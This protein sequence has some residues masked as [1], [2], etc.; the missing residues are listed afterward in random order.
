MVL[1]VVSENYV[2]GREKREAIDC[3]ESYFLRPIQEA[4]L[5]EFGERL[6]VKK[7]TKLADHVGCSASEL[8]R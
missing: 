2:E 6:V 7:R 3:E 5:S 8:P 4:S 1:G